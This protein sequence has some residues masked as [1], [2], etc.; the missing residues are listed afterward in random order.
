MKILILILI[1]MCCFVIADDTAVVQN[2]DI[3]DVK[4]IKIK[5]P[6]SIGE[7]RAQKIIDNM[8]TINGWN[9]TGYSKMRLDNQFRPIYYKLGLINARSIFIDESPLCNSDAWLK[10]HRVM[11]YPERKIIIGFHFIKEF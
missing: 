6:K 10:R 11:D 2:V 7:K 9:L 1:F 4:D 5:M 8:D 3:K